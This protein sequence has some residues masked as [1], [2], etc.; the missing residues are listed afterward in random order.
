MKKTALLYLFASLFLAAPLSAQTA[1]DVARD[2]EGSTENTD[3]S[4]DSADDEEESKAEE[5]K[6]HPRF[7]QASVPGGHFMVAIDRISSI[8][9]HQYVLDAQLLV[10]E[11]V[12]DTSGR[13]LARFYFVTSVAENSGSATAARVVE[14]GRDLLDRAGQ[15]AG[16]NALDL[17]QKNYPTTSH[18]GMV[19]YRMMDLRD[20]NALYKSVQ[21]AWETGK[22]R[23]ITVK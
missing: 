5:S 18:A 7:W 21:N 23:K 1:D 2:V 4:E 22:G 10:T 16:T 11:M 13:S 14:K 12:I 17:A 15:R 6:A 19:E 3:D 9:M 20:L 8:S